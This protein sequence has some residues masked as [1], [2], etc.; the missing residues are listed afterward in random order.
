MTLTLPEGW[1]S[2]QMAK[3]AAEAGLCTE[4]EYLAAA[5][6]ID[7]DFDWMKDI[8]TDENKL[9]VLEASSIRKPT[10]SSPMPPH[11]ISSPPSCGN[12]RRRC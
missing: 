8:S 5:N 2:F 3:A 4:E 12:S 7:Y 9:T 1:N 11:G 6:A 10:P